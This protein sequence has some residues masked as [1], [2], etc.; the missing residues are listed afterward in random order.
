MTTATKTPPIASVTFNLGSMLS[1]EDLGDC[2]SYCDEREESL[3]DLA[4]EALREKLKQI[5]AA[6]RALMPMG[7]Q[8]PA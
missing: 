6:K 4:T 5:R 1:K 2:M 8:V 3:D 7:G